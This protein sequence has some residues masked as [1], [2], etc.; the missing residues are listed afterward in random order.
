[1]PRRKDDPA[2]RVEANPTG[3]LFP[4]INQ[5]SYRRVWNRVKH[6]MGLDNDDQF[7][8]YVPRHT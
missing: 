8:P 2:Q 7:V 5:D 3:K 4:D 6:L 1:M